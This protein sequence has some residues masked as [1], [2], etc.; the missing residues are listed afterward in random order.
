MY[1]FISHILVY[2]IFLSSTEI[3]M[4]EYQGKTGWSEF[5]TEQGCCEVLIRNLKFGFNIS[6]NSICTNK[7]EKTVWSDHLNLGDGSWHKKMREQMVKPRIGSQNEILLC[8]GG[9]Q[10]NHFSPLF[11]WTTLEVF[12]SKYGL[13][14]WH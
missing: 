13:E 1:H 6:E 10:P 8:L 7:Y 2:E 5:H 3:K 12:V 14:G 11:E 4:K 9:I